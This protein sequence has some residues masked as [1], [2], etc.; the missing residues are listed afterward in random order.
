MGMGDLITREATA[1]P[2]ERNR[3]CRILAKTIYREL[4]QNGF[5]HKQI[6]AIAGDLISLVT[7]DIRPDHPADVAGPDM[8]EVDAAEVDAPLQAAAR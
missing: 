1:S 6:V 2:Q 5:D 3:A 4:R 7:A 8:A